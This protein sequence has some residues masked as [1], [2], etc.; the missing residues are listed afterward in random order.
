M[1]MEFSFFFSFKGF[2]SSHTIY[3]SLTVEKY[4]STCRNKDQD[5]PNHRPFSWLIQ[6][7]LGYIWT[8]LIGRHGIPNPFKPAYNTGQSCSLWVVLIWI[9]WNWG[10]IFSHFFLSSWLVLSEHPLPLV[11]P[12]CHVNLTVSSGVIWKCPSKWALRGKVFPHRGFG[13]S[14]GLDVLSPRHFLVT[15]ILVT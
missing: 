6:W 14:S 4:K 13:L 11:S 5:D 3:I 15:G 8:V 2:K 7:I 1:K 10:K 9:P 12:K